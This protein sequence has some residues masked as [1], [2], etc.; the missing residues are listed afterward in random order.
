[1]T[2]LAIFAHY[3][4]GNEIQDYVIEYLKGLKEVAQDIIFVSDS[5]VKEEELEKID[6][7]LQQF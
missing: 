7:K 6:I 2:K 3:D 5:N 4:R 1:M